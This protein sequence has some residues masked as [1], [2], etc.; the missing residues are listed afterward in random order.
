MAIGEG[1]LIDQKCREV[2]PLTTAYTFASKPPGASITYIDEEKA[3]LAPY[4]AQPIVGSKQTI[5]AAPI[6][7]GRTFVRWADGV[8][9]P[10]RAFTTGPIPMTFTAIYLNKVPKLA[11]KLVRGS[12]KTVR[13]IKLDASATIDPEGE[14]LRYTWVFSDR[15]RMRGPVV[16]RRFSRS[17]S[18]S[19]TLTVSDRLGGTVVYK[20]RLSVGR[21]SSIRKLSLKPGR[22]I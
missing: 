8:T 19:V 22:E 18:Y 11:L 21:R 17:G 3:V 5:S 10:V 15:R 1:G 9:D 16:T 20:G 12:S 13:T 6:S 7:V 4:V 2:P 14:P